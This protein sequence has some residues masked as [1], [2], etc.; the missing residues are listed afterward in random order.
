MTKFIEGA[1]KIHEDNFNAYNTAK[2]DNLC[3]EARK[4]FPKGLK[5]ILSIISDIKNE[6]KARMIFNE[7][8]DYIHN[9]LKD[10][11][12][13]I[14]NSRKLIKHYS[15]LKKLTITQSIIMVILT[16]CLILKGF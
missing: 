14:D 11:Q 12:K 6:Q 8:N 1:D 16:I 7:Y 13:A 15:K 10:C 4:N 5:V 2:D 3:I 9:Q